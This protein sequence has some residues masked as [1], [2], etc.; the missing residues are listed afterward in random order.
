M[1]LGTAVETGQ[2]LVCES[3]VPNDSSCF[4]CYIM[5]SKGRS[6]NAGQQQQQSHIIHKHVQTVDVHPDNEKH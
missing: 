4:L 2:L 1:C 5:T 6:L 3:I